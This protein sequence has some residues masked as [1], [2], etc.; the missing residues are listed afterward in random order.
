MFVIAH[1]LSLLFSLTIKMHSKG[2]YRWYSTSVSIYIV[3]NSYRYNIGYSA[4][5][6][7]RFVLSEHLVAS[8]VTLRRADSVLLSIVNNYEHQRDP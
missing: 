2:K 5:D 3:T 8:A 6:I 1:Q 7:D 4:V